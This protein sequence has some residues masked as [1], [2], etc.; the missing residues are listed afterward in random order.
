MTSTRFLAVAAATTVLVVAGGSA[1]RAHT[2]ADVVA[3]P[4]GT[5]ATVTLEPTHGCDG[6]PT[7]SVLI[8]APFPD[9]IAEDVDGWTA[10]ST[11]DGDGNTVL[12]WAGGTLPADEH[13]AFPVEF[14][15]AAD[16][17]TL[18]TFPAVQRC[19]NGE[20][21]AWISGDPASDFPAPRLLVLPDGYELART[22]DEVPLDAPGRDQ[23]VA[24]VDV[25]NGATTTTAAPISTTSTALTT[26]PPPSPAGS[27]RVDVGHRRPIDDRAGDEHTDP[28]DGDRV[29]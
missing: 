3:V 16:P 20:E 2:E 9:A 1:A 18:L 29:R 27:A 17:G 5:T 8:R 28:V 12:E 21:L 6:S 11:P 10:T 26:A 22:I 23:L 7:V 15:V 14:T 24:I 25:D 19:E 4:T 13:G